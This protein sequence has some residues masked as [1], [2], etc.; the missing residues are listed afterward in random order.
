MKKIKYVLIVIVLVTLTLRVYS[1]DDKD[2]QKYRLILSELSNS[3]CQYIIC[4]CEENI[5]EIIRKQ[6]SLA[7]IKNFNLLPYALSANYLALKYEEMCLEC[8]RKH[9]TAKKN[10]YLSESDILKFII[11][12]IEHFVYSKIS[13]N[14]ALNKCNWVDKCYEGDNYS[15]RIAYE[16]LS[17]SSKIFICDKAS[18]FFHEVLDTEVA[19]LI[20]IY[21][22]L[23]CKDNCKNAE[24]STPTLQDEDGAIFVK[25]FTLKD[26][27]HWLSENWGTAEEMRKKYQENPL[28]MYKVTR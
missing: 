13:L 14:K 20:L 7:R 16:Y 17:Y 9:V 6:D 10:F 11:D 25:I 12:T 21:N 5:Y 4:V 2:T 27:K 8:Q 28:P 23:T 19:G 26:I 24:I 22:Y 3:R 1:Q 15:I 18:Y